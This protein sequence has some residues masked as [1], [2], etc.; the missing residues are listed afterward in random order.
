MSTTKKVGMATTLAG[1][2]A[3]ALIG[4][5]APATATELP[6]IDVSGEVNSAGDH[7]YGKSQVELPVM[8]PQVDKSIQQGN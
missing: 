3:A 7:R 5:A 6:V 8:V 2:L 1:G 4:L